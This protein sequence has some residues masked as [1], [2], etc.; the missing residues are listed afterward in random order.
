MAA[1]CTLWQRI[2]VMQVMRALTSDA[3]I[4]HFLFCSYDARS[5]LA[6]CPPCTYTAIYTAQQLC[7]ALQRY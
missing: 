2:N 7:V 3:Y 5:V 1:S 6:C 4:L